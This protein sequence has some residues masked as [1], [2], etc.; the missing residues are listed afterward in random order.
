VCIESLTT[1]FT[2]NIVFRHIDSIAG[3][4]YQDMLVLSGVFMLTHALAWLLYKASVSN[5]DRLINRG[6]LD[7]YLIKPIYTQFMVSI[8]DLDIEDATRGIVGIFLLFYGLQGH[9]SSQIILALPL[10]VITMVVSQIVLYSISIAIKTISFKS[11]Q[12]WSTNAIAW[13]FHDLARY[14]TDIYRGILKVI[15][16][17]VFPLAFVATVPAKALIGTL[18][19]P[20]FFGSFAIALTTFFISRGIWKWALSQYSSASS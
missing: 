12:G 17:L 15:Y 6:D 19:L 18:T 9:D 4:S 8:Y 1:L 2:I 14:P 13:R 20:F 16:T 7:T 5:L 10:F 3:W 11:I